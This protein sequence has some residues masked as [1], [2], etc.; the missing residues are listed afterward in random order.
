MLIILHTFDDLIIP[1]KKILLIVILC[2]FSGMRAQNKVAARIA[3]MHSRNEVFHKVSVLTQVIKAPDAKISRVVNNASFAEVQMNGI[4]SVVT[5]RY[6]SLEIDIP[7]QGALIT[8]ELY[9]ADIFN[10]GF[11]V[12]TD[13]AIDVAYEKGVHYRGVIKGD[14]KSVASLNFFNNELN[15]VVSGTSLGNLVIGKTKGEDTSEYI[16]YSDTKMN[17]LNGFNCSFKD[18]VAEPHDH[19]GEGDSQHRETLTERCVTLYFEIDHDLYLAHDSDVALTTNWMTSVY[20]NVQ[21]LFENDGITVSLRSTFIWTSPDPYSGESSYDYLG[22]FATLRPVFDGDL[23]QLVALDPGGLGGVAA[24]IDGLCSNMN[25]SYSDVDIFYD[26][27]PVFS[28]TIQVITHELGHLMGSRHTHACVWN[29]DDSAIDGCGQQAGYNEGFCDQGPLPGL[30][31]QGT[32]MSY[33][34]LI[35]GIGISFTN[36]FGPQPAA[37]I[38]ENVETSTCLSTDCINTCINTV[39]EIN[40]ENVTTNSAMIS[41]N[42]IGSVSSNWEYSIMPYTTNNASWLPVTGN[43][44]NATSLAPNTYYKVRVR[45]ICSEATPAYRQEIF[46]TAADWCSGAVITDTG[47]TTGLYQ[48]NQHFVRTII[49]NLPQK[50]IRLDFTSFNLELDFDYLYIYDGANTS[51]PQ[52]ETNGYTGMTAPPSVVSSAPD[53]SLTIEFF[54]DQGVTASGFVGIVSCEQ[55]LGAYGFTK[56]IDFTYYPNPTSDVVNIISNSN[57]REI[58]IY[59]VQ[60]RLLYNQKINNLE[61]VVDISSFSNGTYFFKVKFDEKEA[62]FKIM[63]D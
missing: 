26:T 37:A 28:W 5:N 35:G 31:E 8:V 49:P 25:Y 19:D 21:T 48:N 55:N 52:A 17:V 54:S 42:D 22:Q 60:G 41:W 36:G 9:R 11:H 45:P 51:A 34:H 40:V 24:T 39:A 10:A 43:T 63:K 14:S 4:N 3:E 56:D 57:I 27:V 30:F 2:A 23:G 6:E 13:K 38:I 50:K 20:N 62:N 61:S 7:Y 33:C 44:F 12:D 46:A 15:G 16:I 32:I 53:G 18:D 59:N 1:M 58:L 47:G 29:G